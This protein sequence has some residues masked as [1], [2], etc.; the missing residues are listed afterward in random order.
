MTIGELLYYGGIGGMIFSA[1]MLIIFL[2]LFRLRKRKLLKRLRK[3][4][5]GRAYE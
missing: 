1:L 2:L 5:R 4:Y 3:Q